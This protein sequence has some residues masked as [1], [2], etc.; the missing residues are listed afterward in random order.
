MTTRRHPVRIHSHEFLQSGFLLS[1]LRP[2]GTLVIALAAIS[3]TTVRAGSLTE[4]AFKGLSARFISGGIPGGRATSIAADQNNPDVLYVGG[5]T[6]GVWKTENGGMTWRPI[7]DDQSTSSIGTI[8]VY[9]K[10]PEIVWVGTGEGK[11]RY[12]TGVGTGIYK[13]VDGG[14]TWNNM[15]LTAS[16]RIQRIHLHPDNPE[17]VYVAAVGPAYTD[18]EERGVFKSID[19]GASWK[20]VLFTNAGAG[21]ADLAMDPSNP[22]RL[23]AAMWEFRRKPWDFN[24]G[25]PGSG[26]F[27][28]EDGGETWGRLTDADGLPEGELGR[29]GIAFDPSSPGRVFASVEAKTGG[30]YQSSDGGRTWSL[31][32]NDP[33]IF[34]HYARAWYCQ[35]IAVDPNNGKRLYYSAYVSLSDDGGTSFRSIVRDGDLRGIAETHM[36]LFLKDR[37]GH[38]YVATDQGLIETRDDGK[39]WRR[40]ENLPFAQYYQIS[41][42][43]ETPYNVY[44]NLQD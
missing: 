31:H 37:P 42:D 33:L 41:V 22:D 24:S 16:E 14:Q 21:A 27:L 13:S 15:G 38:F 9:Q 3:L 20:R 12:G 2:V 17:V 10:S 39:T 35:E 28:S 36:A 34:G 7:F 4:D 30:L 29:I 23:L 1:I 5:A 32:N 11:P 40:F 8:T 26:L 18:G 44:G 43:N 19:G 25:G 6:S